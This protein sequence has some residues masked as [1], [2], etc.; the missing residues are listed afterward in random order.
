MMNAGTYYVGDLCYVMNDEHWDL[1]CGNFNCSFE[2]EYEIVVGDNTI[3]Y[4][5]FQ[6]KYGDG[7]YFDQKG[8][9]YFVDSGSIGCIPIENITKRE[10]GSYI[11]LGSVFNFDEDFDVSQN[12]GVLIFGLIHIDTN[13]EQD[14][15][16]DEYETFSSR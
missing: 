13:S 9:E 2:G 7:S 10:D 3:Q 11:E 12:G 14:D 4:A 5:M 15:E 16:D 1:V 8:N 6:T